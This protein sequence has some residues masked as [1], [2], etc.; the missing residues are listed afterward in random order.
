MASGEALSS[1]NR[2]KKKR[3]ISSSF[4]NSIRGLSN[5]VTSLFKRGN[6]RELSP[7]NNTRS[8]SQSS[9]DSDNLKTGN[10]NNTYSDIERNDDVS[11]QRARDGSQLNNEAEDHLDNEATKCPK[12]DNEATECPKSINGAT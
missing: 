6:R 8:Y 7:I 9:I 10:Q 4:R 1:V 5:R 12:S 3:S 11:G 2:R